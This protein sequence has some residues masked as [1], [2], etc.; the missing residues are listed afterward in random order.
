[1]H[2]RHFHV[3]ARRSWRVSSCGRVCNLDGE[4]SY[5]TLRGDGYRSVYIAN[6]NRLVHRLVARAFLG[7][8]LSSVRRQVN[9][10]DCNKAN[11]HVQNLEYVTP[12]E[13]M[14]HSYARGRSFFSKP[15]L[16]R[17]AGDA[18]WTMSASQVQVVR[19]LGLSRSV[20]CRCYRQG[21]G[22][23]SG[24]ELKP[25]FADT[26]ENAATCEAISDEHWVDACHPT[27][28][29]AIS[30]LMV[31]TWGRVRKST[32]RVSYGTLKAGYFVT[33]GRAGYLSVHRLVAAT[34]LGSPPSLRSQVNHIDG[35][36]GNNNV[37]NLEY[38]TP[39][40]NMLHAYS[41]TSARRECSG[42]GK[43]V[44]GCPAGDTTWMLFSSKSQAARMAS[45]PVRLVNKACK[46]AIMLPNGWRF[47][48]AE[49]QDLPGEEWR[50]VILN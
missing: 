35:N 30:G 45:I 49:V 5:G 9:H 42:R 34:F 48:M 20:V 29:D 39:S 43:S 18:D 21:F 17:R 44:L 14:I 25:A 15:I 41:Q 23:A 27:T 19:E 31:S 32:G 38:V 33:N 12:S 6:R 50:D 8:Q 10:I 24:F 37:G 4:V 2:A 7:A 16:W 11:N 40:E 28:G 36:P 13:N 26:F 46:E 3:A 22:K 47:L 1:M